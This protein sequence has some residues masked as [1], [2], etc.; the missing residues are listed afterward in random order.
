MVW[1]ESDSVKKIDFKKQLPKIVITILILF[2]VVGMIWGLKTVLEI[3][4]TMEPVVDKASLSPVPETKEELI[5]YVLT[6][7]E[8]A[9]ED[10]P[11]ASFSNVYGI[12]DETIRAGEAQKT[13]EFIRAGIEDKL[14]AVR[15]DLSSDYGEVLA[16]QL[17][18]FDVGPDDI[19]SAELEFEYWE[20]PGCK[21]ETDEK[22][23]I[24]DY[25]KTKD[26]FVHKFKDE[27]TITLHA[28]DEVYP[29]APDSFFARNFR[30]LTESQLDQLIRDHANGWF[31]C[32]NAFTIA[33]RNVKICA[34]INRLT[35]QI[36]SL[37]YSADC[38]FTADVTFVGKYAALKT[39][40][41]SFT[42]NEETRFDFTWPGIFFAEEELVLAPG[43]TNVLNPESPCAILAQEKLT[44]KSSDESIATVNHEGY[45]SAKHKTG[46]CYVTVSFVFKGETYTAKCPVIVK[47]SA[48][49]IKLSHRKRKLTVGESC[50][51]KAKISPRNA[52]IQ[53]VKWHSDN[54]EIAVV[55]PDGTITAKRS[56]SVDIYAVSDDGYFRATCHVEVV[57]P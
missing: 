31:T 26:G 53:A 44:W 40:T 22:P 16:E 20:C 27:Y 12:D 33:Y 1:K 14:G 47:I 8:K 18:T 46:T 17:R 28:S 9:E 56:G 21:K 50:T 13:A 42:V 52:T 19:T 6:A 5:R 3:E 7:V 37:T 48:E 51:L 15:G 43:K 2:F 35:D 36:L 30:P 57:E 39:Q 32:D 55:D 11:A 24:C 34:V 4:G 38:D 10:K 23:Q 54:E 45:V 29:T 41:V 49:S 25:C